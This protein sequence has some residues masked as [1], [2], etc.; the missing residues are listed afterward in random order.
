MSAIAPAL[1]ATVA[2]LVACRAADSHAIWPRRATR[3]V[4]GVRSD[5]AAY[6]VGLR[7]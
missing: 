3:K 7:G 5:S 4:T 2:A 6:A 1:V